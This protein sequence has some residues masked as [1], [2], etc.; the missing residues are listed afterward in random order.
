[1]TLSP[2]RRKMQ[3]QNGQGINSSQSVTPMVMSVPNSASYMPI[4]KP[5]SYIEKF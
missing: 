3:F 2:K 1:M 5:Q 4:E